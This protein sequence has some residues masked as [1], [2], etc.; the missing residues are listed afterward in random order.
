MKTL[1]MRLK[2]SRL[3]KKW[4]TIIIFCILSVSSFTLAVFQEQK[5]RKSP[6]KVILEIESRSQILVSWMKL[7]TKEFA[8]GY[9]APFIPVTGA[10][11]EMISELKEYR[12]ALFVYQ[13]D[14]LTFWSSEQIPSDTSLFGNI[15][16]DTVLML[17]NGCYFITPLTI[18]DYKVYGV[19]EIFAQYAYENDYLISAFNPFITSDRRFRIATSDEDSDYFVSIY[20]GFVIPFKLKDSFNGDGSSPVILMLLLFIAFAAYIAAIFRVAL[21]FRKLK[22]SGILRWLYLLSMIILGWLFSSHIPQMSVFSLN[23]L[24]SSGLFAISKHWSSFGVIIIDLFW[25]TAFL[26]FFV[27]ELISFASLHRNSIVLRYVFSIVASIFSVLAAFAVLIFLDDILLN[28]VVRIEFDD[29]FSISPNMLLVLTCLF[30]LVISAFLLFFLIVR[31]ALRLRITPKEFIVRMIVAALLLVAIALLTGISFK[32]LLALLLFLSLF[33]FVFVRWLAARPMMFVIV[34]VLFAAA[35]CTIAVNRVNSFREDEEMRLLS[36]SLATEQD[37]LAESMYSDLLNKITSDT[38]LKRLIFKDVND[39]TLVKDYLK[40]KYF[41]GYFSKFNLQITI[42]APNSELIVQP[43]NQTVEC[44]SFFNDM[45]MT[46]GVPC[47]ARDLYFINDGSGRGNYLGIISLEDSLSTA[48]KVDLYI[49][50]T[51]VSVEKGLGYPELLVDQKDNARILPSDISFVRYLNGEL[52]GKYGKYKYETNFTG[53]LFDISSGNVFVYNGYKHLKTRLSDSLVLIISRPAGGFLSN[54]S[55]FPYLLFFI[56]L[57]TFLYV[58]STRRFWNFKISVGVNFSGRL[59]W[60]LVIVI[61]LA[62]SLTGSITIYNLSSLNSNKNS[63]TINEKAHSLMIEMEHKLSEDTVLNNEDQQYLSDLLLKFSNV[64]FTDINVY[65][66]HGRLISSSRPQIFAE[67]LV[68]DLM[69]PIAF[70]Q[71]SS[72]SSSFF[73]QTEHIGKME[74]TS[75]YVPIRNFRN[76]VIGFLNLPYFAKETELNKEISSFIT[77]F[78]NIYF[79]FFLLSVLIALVVSN[80]VTKPLRMI[81]E[82]LRGIKLGGSNEKINWQ[83]GD[84]IGGLITDYNRMIDELAEKADLLARNEREMAWRE[85]AKQVAH[86]IKN[87]LT[88]IKLSTQYLAKAWDEKAPDFDARLQ[89]YTQTLIEQ[90]DNLSNIASEFSNFGKLPESHVGKV[91]INDV[92]ASVVSLFRSEDYNITI[93]QP[94]TAIYVLADESQLVRVFNNLIK[95][96]VQALVSD[97]VGEI[98]FHIKKKDEWV[99]VE[100]KDNGCGIDDIQKKRIFQPN[101]TTKSSG[102]GLGLAMVKNIIESFNGRISFESEP[103]IGSVFSISIPAADPED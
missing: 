16:G 32:Q 35:F 38:S 53:K 12:A 72:L 75:A 97:R 1:Q 33:E 27:R 15:K 71:M 87:P 92:V 23:S 50:L 47:I 76:Q 84:E 41:S 9:K 48:Q 103:N 36:L 52:I 77:A 69:N 68:S 80:Y 73:S 13:N 44:R 7:K 98:H 79:I 37:P 21:I 100:I 89:R 85:M 17:S 6:Q 94:E 63:E 22:R 25:T 55:A 4:L 82:R 5:S 66:L 95:N 42:C 102:T 65:D 101:F 57:C 26:S 2:I 28:T 49:E 54:F 3:A 39:A 59:Q 51:P 64:F 99:T 86:E 20:P 93:D 70:Y 31:L 90:I 29:L 19:V 30:L 18:D 60:M 40:S 11:D 43:Y 58:L 81:K 14:S 91:C 78:I 88:P 61:I 34:S 56:S 67:G 96:A 24:F 8:V 46:M 83:R 74:Y 45:T 10:N 62:F